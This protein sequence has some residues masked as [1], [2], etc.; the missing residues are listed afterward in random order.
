MRLCFVYLLKDEVH[1]IFCI[2]KYSD[3]V[4]KRASNGGSTIQIT[5][6]LGWF[7]HC[8]VIQYSQLLGNLTFPIQILVSEDCEFSL[9]CNITLLIFL[10]FNK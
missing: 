6:W 8:K 1:A 9:H 7:S 2:L 3:H 4:K 10:F 5:V